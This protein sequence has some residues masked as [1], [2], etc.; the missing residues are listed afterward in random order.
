MNTRKRWTRDEDGKTTHTKGNQVEI[1]YRLNPCTCGCQG[2]D[3]WHQKSY[4][5][6]IKDEKPASGKVHTKAFGTREICRE[7]RAQFPWGETRVVAI[8]DS[9]GT[10][11]IFWAIDYD[12]MLDVMNS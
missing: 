3:P 10:D 2:Q 1:S 9:L 7:G 4:W 11:L 5:R 8:E 6:V 12:D